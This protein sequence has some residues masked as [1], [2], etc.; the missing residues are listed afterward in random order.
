MASPV[1]SFTGLKEL[2]MIAACS[3]VVCIHKLIMRNSLPSAAH[4]VYQNGKLR[5][6]TDVH[7]FLGLHNRLKKNESQVQFRRASQ[8]F[9]RPGY[10]DLTHDNDLALLKLESEVIFTDYIL[11][12]CLPTNARFEIKSATLT[13]HNIIA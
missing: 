2:H 9:P 10:D 6:P 3:A 12:I 11:P 5:E 7:V 13:Q 8:I 1:S 4:C